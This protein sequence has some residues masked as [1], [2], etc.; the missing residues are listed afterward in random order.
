MGIRYAAVQIVFPDCYL[1]TFLK[2]IFR[3]TSVYDSRSGMKICKI[4]KVKIKIAEFFKVVLKNH[5]MF[6]GARYSTS[7]LTFIN[8]RVRIHDAQFSCHLKRA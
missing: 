2:N 5:R 6:Q 8:L 7:R 3:N 1:V 4:L